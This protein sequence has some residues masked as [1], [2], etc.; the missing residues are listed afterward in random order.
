MERTCPLEYFVVFYEST[1]Q[2]RID[3]CTK[4]KKKPVAM[5]MWK[6][7][8]DRNINLCIS[9]NLP[10]FRM[11]NVPHQSLGIRT[12]DAIRIEIM[13]AMNK[14]EKEFLEVKPIAHIRIDEG[15]V[16]LMLSKCL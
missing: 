14:T 11:S 7:T 1:I 16:K 9:L 4:L 3:L 12:A 10:V 13:Q 6:K 5:M 8:G 2:L 15:C